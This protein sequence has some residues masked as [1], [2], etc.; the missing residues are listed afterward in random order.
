MLILNSCNMCDL[1]LESAILYI[2][3]Y[4]LCI[5]R[6]TATEESGAISKSS[7]K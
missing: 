6:Y 3:S 1:T 2:I 5:T 7:F 4:E